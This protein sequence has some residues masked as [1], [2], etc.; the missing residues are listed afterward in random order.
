[1]LRSKILFMMSGSIAGFKAC[2]VISRLVQDGHEVQVVTTASLKNFIGDATLE[3]L[4]GKKVLCDVFESGHAMDHI[5]LSRWADFG[6]LCPASANSIA[7]ASLGF[8]DDLVSALILAWPKGKPLH[9]FPA[10]NQQMWAAQ[11]T[12]SHIESLKLRGFHVAPT[13]HGSLACGEVGAG[14]LLEPDQ[15]LR[16]LSGKPVSK[17]QILITAG[18]TREPIDGIRFVSNVSTGRT[19]SS[20]ADQLSALGWSV[21]YLHGQGAVKSQTAR[22]TLEF[23]HFADLA[24]KLKLEL[25]SNHFDGVIHCAAVSDYSPIEIQAGKSKLSPLAQ[26][27]MNSDDDLVVSFKRNPKILPHL[28]DYSQNKNVKVVGFKLTL[29]ASADERQ[30]AIEKVWS[31]SVDAVVANDWALVSSDRQKHPGLFLERSSSPENFET[32]NELAH[33]LNAFFESGVADGSLS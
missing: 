13:G 25:G 2:Q 23:S 29:N 17:G 28:K 21:I 11:P 15:I 7:K 32:L 4:T 8:A 18:A 22:R 9:I 14:R 10:M 12:Q 33:K 16:L 24:D 20:L 19:G 27:K 5:Q 1:M 6:V 26:S 30:A 31:D 3:G